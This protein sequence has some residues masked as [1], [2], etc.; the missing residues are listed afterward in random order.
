M[1][2]VFQ[3]VVVVIG[4]HQHNNKS[5]CIKHENTVRSQSFSY[6][7]CHVLSVARSDSELVHS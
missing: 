3:V 2:S 5:C 4:L 6:V 7:G 1:S